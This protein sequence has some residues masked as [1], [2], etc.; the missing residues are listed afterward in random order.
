MTIL[1]H[2][3]LKAPLAQLTIGLLG[4]LD[5]DDPP[6]TDE[7]VERCRDILSAHA[8]EMEEAVDKEAALRLIT[9]TIRSLNSLHEACGH[10]LIETSERDAIC[11]YLSKTLE[12]RGFGAATEDDLR[13]RDW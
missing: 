3:A 11:S 6:Y 13:A 2:P 1:N 8:S 4:M 10:S 5:T 12:L 7:D 9:K